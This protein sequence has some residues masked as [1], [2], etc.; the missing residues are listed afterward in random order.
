[1]LCI[2]SNKSEL[3]ISCASQNSCV[4]FFASG[5]ESSVLGVK[6]ELLCK[7]KKVVRGCARRAEFC[8][9]QTHAHLSPTKSEQSFA[10]RKSQDSLTHTIEVNLV[11]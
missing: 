6:L 7:D 10:W 5:G 11:L 1:L 8:V 3:E 2:L 9:E 4:T